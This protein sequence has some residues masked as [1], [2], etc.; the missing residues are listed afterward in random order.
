MCAPLR[1]EYRKKFP[2]RPVYAKSEADSL[3]ILLT[4]SHIWKHE[5]EYRLVAQERSRAVPADTPMTD[6]NLLT[7]PEGALVSVI[8]GCQGEYDAVKKVVDDVS[9]ELT[10]KQAMRVPDR[11]HLRID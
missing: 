10:V 8:V 4:K 2:N 3:A 7:Y 9:P 11:F 6:S 1:V 5:R